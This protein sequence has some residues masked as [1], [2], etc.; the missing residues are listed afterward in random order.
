METDTWFPRILRD[1]SLGVFFAST[2]II[3]F[4]LA[5]LFGLFRAKSISHMVLGAETDWKTA[6]RTVVAL[7]PYSVIPTLIC[8]GLMICW[9]SVATAIRTLQPYISMARKATT[10]PRDP[11]A[12]V[13]INLL[14]T[15]GSA[16]WKREYLLSAVALCAILS[17]VCEYIQPS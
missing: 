5:V 16:G 13:N 8:L 17:Q 15:I 12:Y 7:A 2:I 6:D 4:I 14:W 1:I 9:A 10:S 11:A 3:T